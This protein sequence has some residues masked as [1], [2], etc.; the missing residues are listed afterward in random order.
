[1]R[2]WARRLHDA[3]RVLVPS[4]KLL[5]V[6]LVGYVICLYIF[7]GAFPVA[8]LGLVY[9]ILSHIVI[10]ALVVLRKDKLERWFLSTVISALMLYNFHITIP[11]TIDRSLSVH[12]L[13]NLYN[14][15]GLSQNEIRN[16]F[17]IGYVNDN[18]MIGRR[19]NEQIASGN[20]YSSNG[21]IKLTVRG[22]T[23]VNSFRFFASLFNIEDYY[24]EGRN[25][26][27]YKYKEMFLH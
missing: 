8:Y 24:A 6:T 10:A 15:E 17:I 23:L 9:I 26:G 7:A 11:V 4:L 2:S 3:S 13:A 20:V 18:M 27:N 16:R 5:F 25:D 21:V 12:M 1:M 19:I 14:S 22:K